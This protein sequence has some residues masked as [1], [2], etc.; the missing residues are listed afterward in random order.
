LRFFS[1]DDRAVDETQRLTTHASKS[2]V[3]RAAVAF[4]DQVWSSG[5]G[6]FQVV[7]CRPDSRE[8]PSVLDA[9]LSRGHAPGAEGTAPGGRPKTEKSI[10]I[11][12]TRT[13]DERIERLIATEA[14]NTF[15]EVIRRAIRLYAAAV[16]RQKEGWEVVALSPS[17]D[18]LP[19]TVPGVG[20]P[21]SKHAEVI[22]GRAVHP[23]GAAERRE[24]VLGRSSDWLPRSLV[25]DVR[26]LA[27]R[28]AC[29]LDVLLVDMIRT[30]T[31]ARLKAIEEGR[32]ASE[33]ESPGAAEPSVSAV[34]EVETHGAAEPGADRRTETDA[35]AVEKVADTLEQMADNI[36]K[37]MQLV[38]QASVSKG[39]QAQFSDLLFGGAVEG[40]HE[41]AA[42]DAAE[43]SM[44]R[45][46]V[47]AKE[48]N[49]R[50]TALVAL[51]QRERKPKGRKRGEAKDAPK[52]EG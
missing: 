52:G 4:F 46:F 24:T 5:R 1:E 44:Q 25:K 12:V 27:V 21:P 31:F 13:D 26:T 40:A 34:E 10:E 11:R 2:S 32:T 49:E 50:L 14:A 9:V 28:E 38:G 47:R 6:G 18:L 39:Q 51:T 36:E 42:A 48:L 45:L 22:G 30:E 3:I 35:A 7:Y 16:S 23:V 41:E 19:L 15:S 17:G 33:G 20:S 29:A 43:S 37:V 8:A